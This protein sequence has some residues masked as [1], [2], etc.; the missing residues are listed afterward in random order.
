MGHGERPQARRRRRSAACRRPRSA[1]RAATWSTRGSASLPRFDALGEVKGKIV[2]IDFAS[3]LLVDEHPG[4]RGQARGA[5]AVVLTYNPALH[6]LLR[7]K[8]RR[9][10][11][12]RRLLRRRRLPVVYVCQNES[13]WLKDLIRDR[14]HRPAT[15]VQRRDLQSRPTRGTC[16]YNVYGEVPGS[17][18]RTARRSST[19]SHHD[20]YFP[21]GPRRHVSGREPHD[22]QGHE[23]ERL[24]ARA[25]D[26]PVIDL[27]GVRHQRLSTTD[28]AAWQGIK[29]THP[30][31]PG[32][33]V[34]FVENELLGYK[35][36]G[37]S[38]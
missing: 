12:Q 28:S 16:G 17:R 27:R 1:A 9:A 38:G 6:V 5:K 14:V 37:A 24:Q 13:N 30:D 31:W 23:D 11:H 22:G 34:G 15:V 7:H 25:H 32:K 2:I 36:G 35:D 19:A 4:I 3:G 20:A 29:V 18:Q 10:R 33:V 8:H 21:H 26:R